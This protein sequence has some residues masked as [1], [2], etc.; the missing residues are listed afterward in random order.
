LAYIIYTS[1]T[2]GKPKGTLIEH[3]NVVRLMFNDKFQFDF[4]KTDVW[5]LFHSFCFDFSVWEMYGALLY[6][7]KL[8]VIPKIVA[9]DPEKYLK[10]LKEQ[11]VTVLNQTPSAFYH[12][13]DE[14][15]KCPDKYLNLKYVIFGG[16]ALNP[17]KLSEWYAA[18][19]DTKLINMFGITETTVHVTFKQLKQREILSGMSNIGKPIPT[20]KT[21]IID[22]NLKLLPIGVPGECCVGGDG[23]ARGYLNRPLLTK[24]KFIENPYIPGER[25]YKSGDLI[26]LLTSGD[27]EYLGRIDHQVKIRGFRI[28]LGEI[29]NQLLNHEG[30]KRAVVLLKGDRLFAYITAE[31]SFNASQLREYLS[32]RLP[33]YMI[34]SYFMQLGKIPLTSN[35]KVDHKALDSY[36]KR[37]T[38]D[39]PYSEP[40]NE[41]EKKIVGVWKE[42][43]SLDKIGIHDNYFE[44]GGTSFD[45]IRINKRLK[46]LFQIE[47]PVVT[48]FRY[49]T[50]HSFA[51]NYLYKKTNEIRDREAVF[52][53]G[54]RDK[55]ERL[56]RRRGT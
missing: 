45:I 34:P 6:G 8:V 52:K 25:W 26:R 50:V 18:Y 19:P 10:Q 55:M 42:V 43:L 1:G 21:Y 5:T 12:L 31:K 53:R 24:E 9:R 16:E 27:M 20:L 13:I 48:M 29:E 11:C 46:D 38:L 56:Q 2:T 33:D 7:A 54:K 49:T 36:G 40:R 17:A 39:I 44:L 23:V 28:E 22:R 35:G 3:G 47:V 4:S 32:R 51:N 41:I 15:L 14:E 37:L 30:I